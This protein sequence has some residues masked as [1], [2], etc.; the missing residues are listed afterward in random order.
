MTQL[1]NSYLYT[2]SRAIDAI[3]RHNRLVDDYNALAEKQSRRRDAATASLTAA[4][5]DSSGD[6]TIEIPLQTATPLPLVEAGANP[7]PNP[8]DRGSTPDIAADGEF[9]TKKQIKA[10]MEETKRTSTLGAKHQISALNQQVQNL[11]E[12]LNQALTQVQQCE[13]QHRRSVGA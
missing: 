3:G 12:Q 6:P 9:M 1:A 10:L 11:R 4:V 2:R 13:K 8:A 7:K 5:S